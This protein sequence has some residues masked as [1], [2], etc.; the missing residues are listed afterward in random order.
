MSERPPLITGFD[1]KSFSGFYF[2]DM[3]NTKC[4]ASL[5]ITCQFFFHLCVSEL[6]NGL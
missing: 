5:N 1:H 3:K 6:G 4:Q 2:H